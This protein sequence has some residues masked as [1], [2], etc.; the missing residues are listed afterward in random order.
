MQTSNTALPTL[1]SPR[2]RDVDTAWRAVAAI[3]Q[4]VPHAQASMYDRARHVDLLSAAKREVVR[5][6]RELARAW[7]AEEDAAE[8]L[9][10]VKRF[11]A[12][13]FHTP[14]VPS[15]VTNAQVRAAWGAHCAALTA[16]GDPACAIVEGR[17]EKALWE[18]IKALGLAPWHDG[19]QRGWCG[20]A[21]G[22]SAS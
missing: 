1:V 17:S 13:R 16:A 19:E 2:Q 12:A 10:Q 15:R 14:N 5:A 3:A 7:E 21:L 8:F 11:L 9:G 4:S 18:A 6:E 20:L 22:G